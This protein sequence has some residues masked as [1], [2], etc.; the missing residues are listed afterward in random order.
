MDSSWLKTGSRKYGRD[1]PSSI[2]R[3]V[4]D[5]RPVFDTFG[6]FPFSRKYRINAE[7]RMEFRLHPYVAQPVV[8]GCIYPRQA[9]RR[10]KLRATSAAGMAYRMSFSPSMG[11]GASLEDT[12]QLAGPTALVLVS[13]A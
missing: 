5:F 3:S 2:S 10:W 4:P 12:L 13:S 11:H 7:I 1:R 8:S 9:W 6:P